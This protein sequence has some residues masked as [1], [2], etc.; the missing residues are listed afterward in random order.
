MCRKLGRCGDLST[1]SGLGKSTRCLQCVI[2]KTRIR[3]R[4]FGACPQLKCLSNVRKSVPWKLPDVHKFKPVTLSRLF[5]RWSSAPI[6][7]CFKEKVNVGVVSCASRLTVRQ[8]HNVKVSFVKLQTYFFHELPRG[9]GC[10][11]LVVL[12][13]N[14]PCGKRPPAGGPPTLSPHHQDSVFQTFETLLDSGKRIGH[15]R[16]RQVNST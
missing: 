15:T 4:L 5:V 6:P 2:L 12:D 3:K 13:F 14:V 9:S 16:S 8:M 10:W 11:S 7:S 1:D